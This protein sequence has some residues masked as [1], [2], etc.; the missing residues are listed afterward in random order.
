MQREVAEHVKWRMERCADPAC[1]VISGSANVH[2]ARLRKSAKSGPPQVTPRACPHFPRH[3]G[4]P[5]LDLFEPALKGGKGLLHFVHLPTQPRHI[6]GRRREAGG[7]K[8]PLAIVLLHLLP[9]L[10]RARDEHADEQVE[11]DHRA[12]QDERDEVGNGER[13][14]STL[15]RLQHIADVR[16]EAGMGL[17][18]DQHASQKDAHQDEALERSGGCKTLTEGSHGRE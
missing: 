4:N 11:R 17:Q 15:R 3:E 5:L 6:V 12:E 7:R 1:A 9:G 18:P 8:M 10:V 2:P 14:A 16:D 13:R